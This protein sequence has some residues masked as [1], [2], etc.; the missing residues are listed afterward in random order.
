MLLAGRIQLR[1]HWP[2]GMGQVLGQ[3]PGKLQG[4]VEEEGVV[5]MKPASTPCCQSRELLFAVS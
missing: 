5:A 1:W 4:G 3:P 2:L